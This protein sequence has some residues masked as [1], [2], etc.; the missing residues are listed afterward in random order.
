MFY[1]R[2]I[3]PELLAHSELPAV[4]VLTG[5]RR[6]GKTIGKRKYSIIPNTTAFLL[7]LKNLSVS[8]AF[9]K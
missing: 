6:T 5:M 9:L 1:T 3:Y 4:T 8:E 2:K 7:I